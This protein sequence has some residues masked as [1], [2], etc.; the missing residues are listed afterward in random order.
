[1]AYALV[2]S[3]VVVALVRASLA[4]AGSSS[5]ALV[6]HAFPAIAYTVSATFIRA[7]LQRGGAFFWAS[8]FGAIIAFPPFGTFAALVFSAFTVATASIGADLYG[9]C[10]A[11]VTGI[12]FAGA[13]F[14]A[15]TVEVAHFLAF[16][17]G[18][19]D[20]GEHFRARAGTFVVVTNTIFSFLVAVIFAGLSLAPWAGKFL[21]VEGWANFYQVAH[22]GTVN[23]S[24]VAVAVVRTVLFGAI[25]PA[26][27]SV[28]L[29]LSVVNATTVEPALL[30]AGKDA[31]VWSGEAFLALAVSFRARSVGG[32]VIWARFGGTV[33]A[34]P[35]LAFEGGNTFAHWVAL[36]LSGLHVAFPV[37]YVTNAA[38]LS[39][40]TFVTLALPFFAVTVVPA[41]V[42]AG[43]VLAPFAGP[44]G[45]AQ[46]CTVDAGSSFL[47]FVAVHWA[48]FIFAIWSFVKLKAFYRTVVHDQS[49][50]WHNV[51]SVAGGALVAT[52]ALAFNL[53]GSFLGR[54]ALSMSTA[55]GMWLA[56][57]GC[58]IGITP[59]WGAEA[60][61]V[62]ATATAGFTKAVFRAVDEITVFSTKPGIANAGPISI[63]SPV[64]GTVVRA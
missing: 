61:T 28:T 6:A 50:V 43:F 35:H 17:G 27:A 19:V 4:T 63:T 11:S 47:V 5:E 46:A 56:H 24:T 29:A 12:A 57:W 37:L 14:H 62:E 45:I 31:T 36:A 52:V 8:F 15:A 42:W 48:F 51:T 20:T 1:L 64:L 33:V 32:A 44:V 22:A 23:A 10:L 53:K 30:G 41:V 34:D 58:A 3:T 7:A 59:P 2:A 25:S 39:F 38:Q 54:Q 60:S 26:V 18:A 21:A 13:V 49:M 9:T 16:W 55:S 40:V